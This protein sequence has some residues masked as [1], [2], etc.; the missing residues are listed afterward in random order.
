MLPLLAGGEAVNAQQT[1]SQ[2]IVSSGPRAVEERLV[3]ELERHL[4]QARSAPRLLARPVRVVVPSRSLAD[5]VARLLVRSP[6][7]AVAGVSIQTLHGLALDVLERCGGIVPRSEA[8]FPLFVRRSASQQ[9]ALRGALGELQQ[10]YEI[11]EGVVADLLDAGFDASHEAPVRELMAERLQPGVSS[12][13]ARAVVRT[14][15]QT[16]ASLHVHGV[17]HRSQLLRWARTLIERDAEATLP[18]RSVLIHGFADATGTAS[19]LIVALVRYCNATVLLDCPTEPSSGD[20]NGGRTLEEPFTAR[21][22][23]RLEGLAP[24]RLHA[25]DESDRIEQCDEKRSEEPTL[26]LFSAPGAIAEVRATGLRVLRLIEGG[27]EPEA[28]ALVFRDPSDYLLPIRAQ[29][30]RL[31]IPFSGSGLAGPQGGRLARRMDALLCVIREGPECPAEPW[32]EALGDSSDGLASSGGAWK[33]RADLALGLRVLGI[34]RLADLA[35][36][37]P[38]ERDLR[39]PVPAQPESPASGSQSP[40]GRSALDAACLRQCI[41]RAR[42]SCALWNA[43][44]MRA[45]IGEHLERLSRLLA[46]FAPEG[47]ASPARS[48]ERVSEL[49][50]AVGSLLTDLVSALPAELEISREE[51]VALLEQ[52]LRGV[53]AEGLGGSGGGVQIL[54]VMEARARCFDHLFVLGLNRDVFPR[55]VRE[56][57]LLPDGLRRQLCELLPELPVKR[58]GYDEERYLFSQLLAA[59]P[60]VTLSWQ[61]R[62]EDGRDRAPSTLVERLLWSRPDLCVERVPG[63]IAAADARSHDGRERALAVALHGTGAEGRRALTVALRERRALLRELYPGVSSP[64]DP[65]ALAAGR[66]AVLGE[67]DR[68]A[69]AGADLG[70]Y[71]GFV[72]PIR[73]ALDPRRRTPYVTALEASAR[74]GWRSFVQRILRIETLPDPAASL[75]DID[76]AGLGRVVHSVLEAIVLDAVPPEWKQSTQR[77]DRPIDV[78]WPTPQRFDSIL[79]AAAERVLAD[80]GIASPGLVRMLTARARP[81]L[82]RARE[83]DWSGT[84]RTLRVLGVEWEGSVEIPATDAEG[85]HAEAQAIRFRADRVDAAQDGGAALTFTDY[86]TGRALSS[87]VRPDTRRRHLLQRVGQGELLQAVAYACSGDATRTSGRYLQ[88]ATEGAPGSAEARVTSDDQDFV[89]AFHASA[90]ILLR[91]WNA[92][93]FA[94]RLAEPG[95]RACTACSGCPV[96]PACLKGDSGSRSRLL[97]WADAAL[98]KPCSEP[99]LALRAVWEMR[100]AQSPARES[101]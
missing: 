51:L 37:D 8:L 59:S 15:V 34:Q 47:S 25:S 35:E 78:A 57:P 81:L 100:R 7:S 77:L 90:Q 16:L 19:D 13:I 23:S 94:P 91:A 80:Q 40:T 5:H 11:V 93:S 84:G 89:A 92:G 29:F 76:P 65:E 27:A 36:Q 28:I 44:P 49:D 82:E 41:A 32:L 21:L 68:P 9:S 63:S 72:G 6:R 20:E 101:A 22:R 31:G 54:S 17:G 60:D 67:L 38:P 88:L 48:G 83:L 64:V 55:P 1:V 58:R 14:A 87:A 69:A 62:A 33:A 61:H 71:F 50:R 73:S 85:G 2:V 46:V 52:Q 30:S 98:S 75:A 95:G 70:P 66:M 4:R 99:E 96:S 42:A 56:D 3:A 26:T 12:E 39:L 43:W 24:I 53:G 79:A 18:A 74:C 10:G 86:K 97:A 45:S